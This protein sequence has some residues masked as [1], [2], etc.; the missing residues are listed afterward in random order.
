MHASKCVLYQL[1]SQSFCSQTHVS[2]IALFHIVQ[3][4]GILDIFVKAIHL[5]KVSGADTKISNVRVEGS[6][7][8]IQVCV[9]IF[10]CQ[11]PAGLL[12][13][14]GILWLCHLTGWVLE[15]F[16]LQKGPL[17]QKSPLFTLCLTKGFSFDHKN[18][19]QKGPFQLKIKVSPL[20]MHFLQT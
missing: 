3:N 4:F 20:K 6:R 15:N 5:T 12:P 1:D 19:L 9:T 16:A 8:K 14:H 11:L 17:L 7:R 18:A 10:S 2:L 13:I